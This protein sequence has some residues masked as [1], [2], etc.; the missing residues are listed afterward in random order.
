MQRAEELNAEQ[1]SSESFKDLKMERVKQ[2]VETIKSVVGPLEELT[3]ATQEIQTEIEQQLASYALS[4]RTTKLKP[5]E[6]DA[7]FKKPYLTLPVPGKRE[8]WYFI[9]PRF[10]DIQIGWLDRQTE[11]YNI[12]LVHR[13]VDWLGDT[14]EA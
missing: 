12:F 13:Y 2:L 14:P 3:S 11:A 8:N 1:A 5:E 9:I 10:I 7:F 6:L 4:L